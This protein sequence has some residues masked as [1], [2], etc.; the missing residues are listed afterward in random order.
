MKKR[1]KAHLALILSALH[2]VRDIKSVAATNGT[3]EITLDGP[4]TGLTAKDFVV[5]AYLDEK[6]YQL[7][8]LEFDSKNLK[9]TFK[10]ISPKAY[11]QKL[12]IIIEAAEESP[13][14]SGSG[15]AAV[16]IDATGGFVG[17]GGVTPPPVN[18]R[19]IK[20]IDL[21]NGSATINY[22]G[23]ITGIPLDSL[24]IEATLD[25]E[26]YQLE[27]MTYDASTNTIYFKPLGIDLYDRELVVKV[28]AKQGNSHGI[29]GS[30]PRTSFS[31]GFTP[32]WAP[33]RV[34]GLLIT[35]P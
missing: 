19:D 29:V 20:S 34:R 31:Y 3:I 13:R 11:K 5:K 35:T 28:L 22:H 10:K 23:T 30:E 14:A 16:E 33:S 24:D 2:I 1:L 8:D 7:E 27:D 25:G 26:D 12:S 9:F 6:S 18:P 17:G 4:V 32:A 15:E 21:T